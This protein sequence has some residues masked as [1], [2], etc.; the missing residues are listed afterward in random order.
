M[1]NILAKIE[2]QMREGVYLGATFSVYDQG[3]NDYY[4]G[5]SQPNQATTAGLVYDM[6]S[7]SK[8]IGVGTVCIKLLAKE[9]ISLDDSLATYL[10]NVTNL[11]VTIRQLLTHTSGLDPFIAN[12]SQLNFS[13]LKE[14]M[15]HLKDSKTN[16]FHYTDVNFILLGFML[17]A[18]YQ[19]PLDVIFNR[20]IFEPLQMTHTGFGPVNKAVP[21]VPHEI[22]GLVH[23]PKARVFGVHAGSAGLFSNLD[24][25]KKFVNY[26]LKTDFKL[27]LTKDYALANKTRSIAWDLQD[28]WLLHT[29]YTGPFILLNRKLQK[30]AIFLTNRTYEK[31]DRPQW[32]FDRNELIATIK[33]SLA[34]KKR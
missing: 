20:E 1:D 12:R 15:F 19:E 33:Y 31:D 21:T 5:D 28:D 22:G 26:Y 34:N 16:A 4:V 24:D 2:Q 3:W 17:E 29:G 23:D 10:P 9:Q 27:A 14:A 8:V 11:D 25:M 18:I 6:A 30:A 13:E 32:I 7:V